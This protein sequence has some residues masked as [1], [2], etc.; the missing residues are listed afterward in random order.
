MPTTDTIELNECYEQL[1][2]VLGKI[3]RF[4]DLDGNW[5]EGSDLDWDDALAD[6]YALVDTPY[7]EQFS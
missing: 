5:S 7:R 1:E 6:L 3:R 4:V 2:D